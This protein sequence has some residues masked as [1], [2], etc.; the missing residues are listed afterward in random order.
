[1]KGAEERR[2]AVGGFGDV[3]DVDDNDDDWDGLGGWRGF[4]W[5]DTAKSGP[6]PSPPMARS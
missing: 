6:R 2:S 1:L 3:G 4:H 5:R